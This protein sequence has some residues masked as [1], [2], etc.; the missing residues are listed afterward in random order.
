MHSKRSLKVVIVDDA[1]F[2]REVLNEILLRAGHQVVGF[3]ENGEQAVEAALKL[4]PEL[5]VMDIVMPLKSGIQATIEILKELP[6]TKII[7]CTTVDQEI[8]MMRAVEAGAHDYITKPF[9]GDQVIKIIE[10]VFGFSEQQKET[11]Q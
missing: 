9:K 4:K 3:A 11:Q 5:I 10:K 1:P 7:A 8:M 2:I 6:Q